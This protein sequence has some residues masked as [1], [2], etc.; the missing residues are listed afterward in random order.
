MLL[1]VLKVIVVGAVLLV[2]GVGIFYFST[3]EERPSIK[4]ATVQE[5]DNMARKMLR[6][7]NKEAWDTTRVVQWSFKDRHHYIWD[8][9]LNYVQ[10]KWE[11]IDVRLN[12]D[13]RS[14]YQIFKGK[15]VLTDPI[16]SKELAVN[17]W[18]YFCNDSFWLNAPAKVFDPG[19]KR[20]I[21]IEDGKKGLMVSYESGGVTPG[22]AYLWFL[23]E[24]FLPYKYKMW[25]SI[26]PIGGTEATWAKWEE[27]PTGAMVATEHEMAVFKILIKN[28][29]SA[30][31]LEELGVEENLFAF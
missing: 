5:A 3:N 4:E 10:V 19:T 14:Q 30:Q 27:L 12:I 9:K 21:V 13:N 11:D 25:V 1:K 18:E 8:K 15:E 16:K 26:I 24:R 2:A 20:S 31:S 17:A 23:D 7:I 29:N 28:L 22:D 6:A